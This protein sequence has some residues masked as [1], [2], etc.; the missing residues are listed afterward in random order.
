MHLYNIFSV[1]NNNNNKGYYCMLYLCAWLLNCYSII[2]RVD[3]R[4]F[5]FVQLQIYIFF[6]VKYLKMNFHL[7][8]W[9]LTQMVIQQDRNWFQFFK[10]KLQLKYTRAN[11][12]FNIYIYKTIGHIILQID[13][14][15]IVFLFWAA[16]ILVMVFKFFIMW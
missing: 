12:A 6:I 14:S 3:V 1:N 5:L 2:I 4:E 11:Y 9:P 10:R 8:I 16:K 7:Y 15:S 13:H